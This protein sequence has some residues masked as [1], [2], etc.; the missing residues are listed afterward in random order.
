MNGRAVESPGGGRVVVV[1]LGPGRRRPAAAGG[2]IRHPRPRRP[3][4]G[5]SAPCGIRRSTTWLPRASSSGPATT[6][7]SRPTGAGEVYEAIAARLLAAAEDGDVCFA[8][9]GSP[10]VG[11]NSVA[12]LRERLG[13]RLVLVPGLSFVDLAWLRLGVDPL[14]G[15]GARAVDGKALPGGSAGRAAAGEPLPLEAGAVGREAGAA[16]TAA[17][18]GAG[19]RAGPARACPTRPSSPCRWR[20]STGSSS[21]TTSPRS[22]STSRPAGPARRGS[23]WWRSSS[24]SGPPAAA[25]GTPSRPTT[26]WPATSSRRP[27]RSSRPSRRCRRRRPAPGPEPV[28]AGAYEHL[29]EELGDLACQVIFHSTFGPGGRRL[30]RHRRADRDPRQA[31]PPP[32]PRLR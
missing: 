1:G 17:R 7:T 16:G 2:P 24:G 12:L 29:E 13:K 30:H 31:R 8:V 14:V 25:P 4:G 18:R 23:G 28:P 5:S 10:A 19:H 27:T 20:I 15:A 11:E 21:P 6:S 32:P 3:S 9:P 22:S 26:P